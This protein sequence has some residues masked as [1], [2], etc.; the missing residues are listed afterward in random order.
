MDFEAKHGV[1]AALPFSHGALRALGDPWNNPQMAFFVPLEHIEDA[2]AFA[3]E[4]QQG[5]LD[6]LK[7][8]NTG[9]V[10]RG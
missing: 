6:L 3:Q 4:A 1:S 2:W 10:L 8:P 5:T 7:H 9:S